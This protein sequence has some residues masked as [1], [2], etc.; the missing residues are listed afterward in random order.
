MSV[1]SEGHQVTTGYDRLLA[2]LVGHQ[3]TLGT[4]DLQQNISRL[5]QH[6]YFSL[7]SLQ[8]CQCNLTLSPEAWLGLPSVT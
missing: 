2:S 3:A 5:G 6:R 1:D 7:I 4:I 8:Y